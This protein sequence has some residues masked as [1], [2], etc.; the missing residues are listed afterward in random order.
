A[1]DSSQQCA[2]SHHSFPFRGGR[3]AKILPASY[4]AGEELVV[5]DLRFLSAVAMTAE[6]STEAGVA[7]FGELSGLNRGTALTLCRFW[8][9]KR[10]S[11]IDGL[12]TDR[13]SSS[14]N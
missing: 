4:R 13:S 7:G 1:A 14:W 9:Y 3:R 8:P 11:K 5:S 6:R 2:T 10:L 12:D